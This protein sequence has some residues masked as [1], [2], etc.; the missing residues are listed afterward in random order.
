MIKSKNVVKLCLCCGERKEMDVD[1]SYCAEC[2]NP[3]SFG[4]GGGLIGS[5][6]EGSVYC[7]S[8][9]VDKPKPTK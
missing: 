5:I 2:S 1:T 7:I 3:P 6:S 4:E 8:G 9:I